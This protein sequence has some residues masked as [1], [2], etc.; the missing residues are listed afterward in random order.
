MTI[1]LDTEDPTT[2]PALD[3]VG[4]APERWNGFE[5]PIVTAAAFRRFIAAW[6]AMDPNGTWE[7]TGVTVDGQTLRYTDSEGYEDS[8]SLAGVT[9]DGEATYA[10][11]G[12]V[13]ITV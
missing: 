2:S 10:L 9:A 5:V 12:W 11:D 1:Y 13:W 4:V 6:A 7:P 3:I 8:W